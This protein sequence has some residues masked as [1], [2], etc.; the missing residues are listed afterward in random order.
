M[1][2]FIYIFL[3]NLVSVYVES[4]V[5]KTW[6]K[7]R[8]LSGQGHILGDGGWREGQGRPSFLTAQPRGDTLSYTHNWECSLIPVYGDCN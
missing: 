7:Y 3:K 4:R 1:N 5:R 8:E 6:V 2:L